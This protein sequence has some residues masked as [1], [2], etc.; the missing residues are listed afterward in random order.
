MKLLPNDVATNW[1]KILE[2]YIFLLPWQPTLV[3]NCY[4]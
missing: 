3:E 4:F 2:N 1:A